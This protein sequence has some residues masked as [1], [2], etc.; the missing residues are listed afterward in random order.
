MQA[1]T[2]IILNLQ[3][4]ETIVFREEKP[5]GEPFTLHVAENTKNMLYKKM[6]Y[7]K[8]ISKKHKHRALLKSC[9]CM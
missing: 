1:I 2:I 4:G 9:H 3:T 6:L 7:K 5:T 8:C